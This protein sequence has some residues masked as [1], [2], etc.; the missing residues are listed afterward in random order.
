MPIHHSKSPTVNPEVD[1]GNI[2]V[3]AHGNRRAL[4]AVYLELREL[5]K[6]HD[7]KVE[8]GSVAIDAFNEPD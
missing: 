2:E 1:S 8:Y 3:S 4:E 7:L 5:A 6:R